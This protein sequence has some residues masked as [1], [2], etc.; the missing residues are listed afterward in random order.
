MSK[1]RRRGGTPKKG[2]SR[3]QRF[4]DDRQEGHNP[5]SNAGKKNRQRIKNEK[6]LLDILAQDPEAEEELITEQ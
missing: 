4:D 6:A 3:K 5:R 1:Q 2:R